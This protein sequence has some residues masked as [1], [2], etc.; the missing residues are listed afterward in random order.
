MISLLALILFPKKFWSKIIFNICQPYG[1]KEKKELTDTEIKPYFFGTKY[2]QSTN[3][4][5][6]MWKNKIGC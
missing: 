1:V 2:I 6:N 3:Q 4:Q 5:K